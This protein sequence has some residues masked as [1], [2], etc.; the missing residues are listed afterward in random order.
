MEKTPVQPE[1]KVPRS[2]M[3]FVGFIF[4][5]IVAQKKWLLLPLWILLAATALAILIGGGSSLLPVIYI[6]I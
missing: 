6:A 3:A 1:K 4:R 2:I 5:E